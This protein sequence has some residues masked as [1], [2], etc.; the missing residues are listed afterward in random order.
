MMEYRGYR[1]V[2]AFDDEAD[3]FHGEVAGTRDV[4]TFEGESVHDLKREF[5]ASVDSY[6]AFC[7]ERGRSPDKPFSGN[8]PLRM[9]PEL[10]RAAT[11][12]AREAGM[13][14]NAWLTEMVAKAVA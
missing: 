4:I 2:V 8:V 6:L 1:A 7:E 9:S 5:A 10:H 3:L 12:A 13:S 14:L 11:D